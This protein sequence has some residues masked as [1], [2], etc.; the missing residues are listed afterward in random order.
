MLNIF[1]FNIPRTLSTPRTYPMFF[2]FCPAGNGL[3][4]AALFA[5]PLRLSPFSPV[6]PSANICF[7]GRKTQSKSC[8][9]KRRLID[10]TVKSDAFW[11]PFESRAASRSVSRRNP[12]ICAWNWCLRP[13]LTRFVTFTDRVALLISR[14][15][16][17]NKSTNDAPCCGEEKMRGPH[18]A[19]PTNTPREAHRRL[20]REFDPS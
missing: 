19:N 8:Q 12:G 20:P 2:L 11:P 13:Q 1:A 7:V 3:G 4:R 16:T 6:G 10:G 17:A 9:G 15:A 14:V 18:R 5:L